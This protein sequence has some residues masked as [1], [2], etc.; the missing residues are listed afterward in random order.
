M[1]GLT[2]L[3]RISQSFLNLYGNFERV[4]AFR[5]SFGI[6]R[7]AVITSTKTAR[8]KFGE[9]SAQLLGKNQEKSPIICETIRTT[10]NFEFRTVQTR[11]NL[12]DFGA[13]CK[14]IL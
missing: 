10:A 13:C 12:V 1:F 2:I 14:T 7:N 8:F 5:P 9:I 4:I 6:V 3:D 11:L